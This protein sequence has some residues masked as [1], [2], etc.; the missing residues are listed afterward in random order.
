MTDSDEQP[1][2]PER[3][4]V[5]DAIDPAAE[6]GGQAGDAPDLGALGDLLGGGGGGLDF[7]AL[8]EQASDMQARMAAAQ[9]EL[10]ETEVDGVAGG[11]AVR[12]TVTGGLEFRSVHIRPDAVDPNEVDLLEDLVLAAL[13]DATARIAELQADAQDAGG[14]DLGGLDLGGLEDLFGS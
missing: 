4:I 3:P 1:G 6:S 2:G 8:F 11:G 10:T 13:N 9:Q 14:L 5:P 12:I 7:G